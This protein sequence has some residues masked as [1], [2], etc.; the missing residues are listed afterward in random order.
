MDQKVVREEL[1]LAVNENHVAPKRK[2]LVAHENN[3]LKSSFFAYIEHQQLHQARDHP[4][5][6]Y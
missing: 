3:N 2:H 4:N 6:C 1:G 5:Q